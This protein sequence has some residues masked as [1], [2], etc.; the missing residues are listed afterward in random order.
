MK[1]LKRVAFD[2]YARENMIDFVNIFIT[3]HVQDYKTP[4]SVVELRT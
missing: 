2:K 1:K 4:N 3:E